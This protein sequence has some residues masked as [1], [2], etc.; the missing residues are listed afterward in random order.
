MTPSALLARLHAQEDG[1]VE[2]KSEG[3][4][5]HDLRKTLTAF[6]NS[7]PEGQH[8]IIFIG[9]AD[10]GDSVEGCANTDAVQK[11][12]REA[13][14]DCYP[15][16]HTQSQV[17]EVGEKHVVAVVVDASKDRPHFAGQ[18]YVRQGSE[19]VKASRRVFDE[20]VDSRHSTVAAILRMKDLPITVYGIGHRLGHLDQVE[21]SYREMAECRVWACDVHKVTLHR[22]S[23]SWLFYEA[24][25]RIEIIEDGLMKR[26]ALVVKGF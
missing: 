7:T 3:I 16:I 18:A 24:V 10:R 22:L 25:Q 17:L 9:I 23:D 12:V 19:S 8:A 6:A 5:P 4:K 15:P 26:P 20:L 13:A 11:R 1:L 2:R 21:A 14:D